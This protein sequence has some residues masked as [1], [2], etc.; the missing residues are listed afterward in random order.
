[1]NNINF[2]EFRCAAQN[3][4]SKIMRGYKNINVIITTLSW[5]VFYFEMTKRIVHDDEKDVH[6]DPW[7]WNLHITKASMIG[8]RYSIR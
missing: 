8:N 7:K 4:S 6:K 5:H 3:F 1:M 2:Q